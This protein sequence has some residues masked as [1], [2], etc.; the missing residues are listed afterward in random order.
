[1]KL[2]CSLPITAWYHKCLNSELRTESQQM[3]H[4]DKNNGLMSLRKRS[5][6]ITCWYFRTLSKGQQ[7]N[8]KTDAADMETWSSRIFVLNY[9]LRHHGCADR[10]TRDI[11]CSSG[12]SFIRLAVI[13]N[14]ILS[15]SRCIRCRPGSE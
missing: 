12:I 8:E 9:R 7:Q 11:L 15:I 5:Y 14:C 4:F 1:M 3:K 10:T 6:S 2:S 13:P